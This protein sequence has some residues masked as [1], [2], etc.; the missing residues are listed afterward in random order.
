M[1]TE[2]RIIY[3]GNELTEMLGEFLDRMKVFT[4][5]AEYSELLG[6]GLIKKISEWD[7]NIRKQKDLPLTLTVCGEF[8]RGKSS[9]I[10]AILGEDVVTVNVTTE[11]ITTNRISYGPHKNELV[12]SGGKRM[13]LTDDE[14]TCD[15]LKEILASLP[16]RATELHIS[17][18]IERLKQYTIIDTPGLGDSIEDF[19]P[20]VKNALSQSDAVIYV[21]SA[22]YPIS[23]QERIFIK[24]VIKPQKYT[25]MM[26]VA[27]YAD[28][29]DDEEECARLLNNVQDRISD[30]LPDEKIYMVSALDERCRQLGEARPNEKLAG[31]LENN[32]SEF[33]DNLYR[34]LDEKKEF[35]IPNRVHRLI[36]GMTGELNVMLDTLIQGVSMKPDEIREK[37]EEFS[38]FSEEQRN[39]HSENIKLIEDFIEKAKSNTVVWIDEI[40]NGMESETA[41]LSKFPVEDVKKNYSLYCNDTLR[42]AINRCVDKHT[43]DVYRLLDDIS[44][45]MGK[46]FTGKGI[47]AL[48]SFKFAVHNKSWTKG[49]NVA[50]AGNVVLGTSLLSY[51]TDLVGGA[52]R[53][54]E[55]KHSV[56]DVISDI[57]AQYPSLKAAV[58]SS[59]NRVYDELRDT[60][61]MIVDS[62]FNEQVK[63]LE[64]QLEQAEIIARQNEENKEKIKKAVREIRTVTDSI[65]KD[66]DI[67]VFCE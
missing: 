27:N 47:S 60:V 48:P 7:K 44:S 30:I 51:V 55:I 2:N 19:L 53:R 39:K 43:A 67:E 58:F 54:S 63:N 64:E 36:D 4:L 21:F 6:E 18:P 50:F 41:T 31:Y 46:E 11:T 8:K 33:T 62:H 1:S 13:R 15:K 32:F 45:D 17:R 3:N 65:R 5:D 61:M 35:V 26:L 42:E 20:D 34:I 57:K 37:N 40:I 56:N 25:E 9:L 38:R 66:M 49:D 59:I 24:N 10:N 28:S 14:L 52:M 29:F 23:V 22:R 16:E 12:L